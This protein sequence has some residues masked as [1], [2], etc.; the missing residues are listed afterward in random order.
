MIIKKLNIDLNYIANSGETRSFSVVGEVGAI[1]SI[2]VL[3]GNDYY[4][5]RTQT[6]TTEYKRLKNRK[7]QGG[8]FSGNIVFPAGNLSAGNA[9]VVFKV[10]VFAEQGFGTNHAPVSEVRFADGTYDLNSSNGSNSSLLEKI[11]YQYAD[12]RVDIVAYSPNGT[13]L[14][15][16][17]SSSIISKRGGSSPSIP[18]SF[19]FTTPTS[20]RTLKIL[21]QPIISDIA[22][23]VTLD[24]GH[25]VRTPATDVRSGEPYQKTAAISEGLPTNKFVLNNVSGLA[26]GMT[27]FDFLGEERDEKPIL[28]TAINP[29]GDNANEIQINKTIT[30]SVQ[31]AAVSVSFE[32][33]SYTRWLMPNVKGLKSGTIANFGTG[34]DAN[35]NIQ[36]YVES[37]TQFLEEM[38]SDGSIK[39]KELKTIK[40]EIPAI[41]TTGFAPTMERGEVLTQKGYVNFNNSLIAS[42]AGD[43][44]FFSYGSSAVRLVNDSKLNI[45]NL[46]AE[47]LQVSTT[48]NDANADGA[49]AQSVITLASTE[50]IMNNVSTMRGVNV[51][52]TAKN[53]IVTNLSTT[54]V[55]V[56]PNQF[57]QN[58]QTLFFDNAS[59]VVTISGNMQFE[60]LNS[61]G[62]TLRLDVEK[63]LSMD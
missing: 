47:L 39:E 52:A 14:G 55:T 44:K 6:F 48:V 32:L 34:I 20:T 19:N 28:I 30:P 1:F 62:F 31:G 33:I 40:H 24:I 60:T 11:L 63:F 27:A 50:G 42:R 10:Q 25:P 59:R 3:K 2:V 51:T 46:K 58:T 16:S 37:T 45:T 29:D 15:S 13:V 21:R 54:Q 61:V 22:S 57:L 26:V 12:T 35:L 5:W 53:P 43:V 18:F 49:T 41:D 17:G 38:A 36:P 56:S 7:I 23:F 9:P 4:D 8:S